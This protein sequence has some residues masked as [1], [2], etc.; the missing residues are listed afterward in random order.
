[1][2]GEGTQGPYS[3]WHQISKSDPPPGYLWKMLR[4]HQTLGARNRLNNKTI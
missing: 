2:V 3:V 4:P 1:M